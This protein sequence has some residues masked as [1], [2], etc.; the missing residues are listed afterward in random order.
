MRLGLWRF[1]GDGEKVND[2]IL[3]VAGALLSLSLTQIIIG[4]TGGL[5]LHGVRIETFLGS[6]S[7]AAIVAHLDHIEASG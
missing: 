5:P 7:N 1:H 6:D 3:V 2:S 4:G